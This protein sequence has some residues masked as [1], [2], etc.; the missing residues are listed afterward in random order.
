MFSIVAT[1]WLKDARTLSQL[2]RSVFIEEQQVPEALEWDGL[3]AA[4]VHL[5]AWDMGGN[6]VGCLRLLPDYHLGRMAVLAGHRGQGIG[7]ALLLAGI[8]YAVEA[9]WPHVLLSAQTQAIAFYFKAGFVLTGNE[10][11]DA[12]ISH[13]DM[14]LYLEA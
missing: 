8:E 7:M 1:T 2:R 3:D 14:C 13:R 5:L 12:G 9:R 11:M 4:A 10:Y 6:A